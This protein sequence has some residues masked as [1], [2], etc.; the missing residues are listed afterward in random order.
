MLKLVY[1]DIL[2]LVEFESYLIWINICGIF[3]EYV[4]FYF[5]YDVIFDML[6]GLL[7]IVLE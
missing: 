5:L 4:G 1:F 2:V 3:F 7:I 6:G